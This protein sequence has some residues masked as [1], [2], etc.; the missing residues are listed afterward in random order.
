MNRRSVILSELRSFHELLSRHGN[1]GQ[2]E[3]D[4]LESQN[5]LEHA[6]VVQAENE[7]SAGESE[8]VHMEG[9]DTERTVNNL[10]ELRRRSGI[11][12]LAD[13][14]GYNNNNHDLNLNLNMN[15]SVDEGYKD[16]YTLVDRGV[17]GHHYQ[18]SNGRM[19]GIGEAEEE[20]E[21][22]FDDAPMTADMDPYLE[23]PRNAN[24]IGNGFQQSIVENG[25]YGYTGY[26]EELD[27]EGQIYATPE[28]REQMRARRRELMADRDG[29][30]RE[31]MWRSCG[32]GE[33][34]V[35]S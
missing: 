28:Q 7:V 2:A 19:G 15:S 33:L 31:M 12:F 8:E 3:S 16:E 35:G 30:E 14:S 29:R 10:M 6:N 32:V 9:E 25:R 24:G 17:W 20:E 4:I 23:H 18:S 26:E 5:E 13:V 27:D 11:F 34:G 21:G 1:G 22:M